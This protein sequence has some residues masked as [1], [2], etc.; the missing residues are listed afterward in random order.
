MRRIARLLKRLTKGKEV[1]NAGWLIGGK[2][3][4]MLLSLLVG[5]LSARYLG[6]NNYGLINYGMAYVNFFMSF[7]TLGINSI[8]LKEFIDDPEGQGCTIGTTIVLRA[9]S[10][11][12]SSIM[13]IGIVAVLDNGEP[14]TIAVAALCSISLVFQ[15]FDTINYWFQAQYKS[16]ITAIVTLVAYIITSTYKILLLIL[17]KSVEWFAFASSIDYI[18]VGVLL[19]S[20]YK[21]N[22]GP[23][24]KISFAKGKFLL[25]SSYH[26]ILSG[27]MVSIYAQTDK[28]MLKQMIDESTVGYYTIATNICAMW[29]F[30]LAAIIDSIHPTILRYHNQ[31]YQSYERKNRQLYAIVFYISVFVALLIHLFGDYVVIILYGE[32]YMPAVVPLKIVTWYVAFSYLGAARN[33]WI[34]CENNQKYLKY[35]Y[36][37]AAVINIILN[38]MLIP[39]YSTEGAAIASLITQFCTSIVLPFFIPD[40][41]P[42]CKLMVEGI[43]LKDTFGR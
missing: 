42:N 12:F 15:V 34:I 11:F 6:P 25:R 16:K 35:I 31:D 18:I 23:K 38:L 33:A 28:L 17:G 43:L 26:Y 37:G 19:L 36:F 7:C 14:L 4:Q 20:I 21:K 10:S 30:V 40:M 39:Q 13:I 32:A 22:N 29:T 5:V 8:I 27:M 1:Q 3:A 41:R 24:F 2:I 9:I